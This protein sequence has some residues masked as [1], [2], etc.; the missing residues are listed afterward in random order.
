MLMLIL[1]AMITT[2]ILTIITI[3]KSSQHAHIFHF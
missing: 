1:T 3:I 2:W